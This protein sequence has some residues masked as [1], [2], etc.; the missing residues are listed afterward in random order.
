[1]LVSFGLLPLALWF[2]AKRPAL[3]W[4]GVCLVA[5]GVFLY[6]ALFAAR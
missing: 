3:A 6:L 4:C 5:A 2:S 1:V